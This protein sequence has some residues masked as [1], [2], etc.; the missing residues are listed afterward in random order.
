MAQ[1]NF[2]L[3]A[4]K[5]VEYNEISW[6]NHKRFEGRRDDA[7]EGEREHNNEKL[8]TMFHH[9]AGISLNKSLSFSCLSRSYEDVKEIKSS[10]LCCFLP[11]S[12]L[13]VD[14]SH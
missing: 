3:L 12:I 1:K 11:S 5:P 9:E 10:F 14:F 13:I 4:F 7:G 8:P 6:Q 2:S